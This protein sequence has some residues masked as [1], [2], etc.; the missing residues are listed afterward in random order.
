VGEGAIAM[1]PAI[2]QRATATVSTASFD[3]E[4]VRREFPALDQTVRGKPLVYLDSAASALRCRAAIEAV[5][6]FLREYP[7]NVHRGVHTLSERAT[8]AYEKARA[9]TA[10]FLC[11]ASPREVVFVR[12]TTEAINLV[13]HSFLRPRLGAGDE[14]LLTGLEHHANI[15]PWQL[16]AEERG[17]RLVAAPLDERGDVIVEEFARLLSPRTRIAAVAHTSNA[18]GTVTP[19]AQLIGLARERGVPVLVDGAQAVPHGPVDVGALGCDFFAFSG[20]KA[21]GPNGIGV[22]WGR[23]ALLQSMPPYQGGGSMI[24]AVTFEKTTFAE[25]PERFEAGTPNV[26]GAIGLGAALE[27]LA[28]LDATGLERHESAVLRHATESLRQIEGVRL[29]GEPRRRAGVVS[30]VVDGVHPH[31]AGTI[32]DAEGVAVRAG[33]HC[34]QPVM[35]HF[36]V[37]ATVRA[38]FAPYSTRHEVDVLAKALGKVREIFGR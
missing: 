33:H 25:P 21:Y 20:H 18:L 36:K 10:R 34:A 30:F 6:E 28:S 15:V 9:T 8:A 3:V 4:A 26:E 12:G 11:A 14:I 24:H 1:T 27:W 5:D 17:A 13:A 35:E 7:A 38:S 19:L 29:I 31:D 32:L 2:A 22:L 37:P 23:S 16:V